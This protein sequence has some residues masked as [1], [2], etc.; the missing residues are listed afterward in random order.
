MEN[1]YIYE[2]IVLNAHAVAVIV[3]DCDSPN[4]RFDWDSLGTI[5]VPKRV[6]RNYCYTED[7]GVVDDV[8]DI[9]AIQRSKKTA[10]YLPVY[11]YSHSGERFSTTPFSCRWDSG[12]I[13]IIACSKEEVR[14]WYQ[15]KR[16]TKKVL[17]KAVAALNSE[18]ETLDQYANG[19]VYSVWCFVG[20]NI[21]QYKTFA[22]LYEN[23]EDRDNIGGYYGMKYATECANADLKGLWE[24]SPK[25]RQL[26]LDLTVE[27]V[28]V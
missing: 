18:V 21:S 2:T 25:G 5:Y 13:G 3:A 7:S 11:M 17:A 24:H 8:E 6:N 9:E 10:C 15:V 16:V 1:E 12:Q 27:G 14:N 4:P 23:A 22:E 19:E 26:T 20:H 28:T